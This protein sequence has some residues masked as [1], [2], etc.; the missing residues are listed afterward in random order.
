MRVLGDFSVGSVPYAANI[1]GF[2]GDIKPKGAQPW[3][4]ALLE[5][6]SIMY[7]EATR[8][9]IGNKASVPVRPLSRPRQNT[10]FPR[11][12]AGVVQS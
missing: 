11:R 4:G 2:G 9:G 7:P 5:I 10:G 3:R 1:G 8:G 6:S 12:A